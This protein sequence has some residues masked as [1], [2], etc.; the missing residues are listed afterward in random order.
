MHLRWIRSLKRRAKFRNLDSLMAHVKT[1][2]AASMERY[3]PKLVQIPIKIDRSLTYSPEPANNA[4]TGDLRT[5]L[6]TELHAW[7]GDVLKQ[8]WDSDTLAKQMY[9][10]GGWRPLSPEQRAWDS[11]VAWIERTR[12]AREEWPWPVWEDYESMQPG[13][14]YPGV[15]FPFDDDDFSDVSPSLLPYRGRGEKGAG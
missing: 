5:E 12:E 7:Y 6:R 15:G 14:R 10:G 4:F 13:R 8:V 11:A 1:R 2:D 3:A 9:G